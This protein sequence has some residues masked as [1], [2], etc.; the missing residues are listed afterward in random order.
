MIFRGTAAL[1]VSLILVGCAASEYEESYSR[2]ELPAAALVY[3]Q[4]GEQPLIRESD[5]L[6]GELLVLRK[7]GY[8]VLGV[9]EFTGPQE[10]DRGL[11]RQARRAGATL[12]LKSSE[13]VGS[14]TR[15]GKIY[16]PNSGTANTPGSITGTTRGGMYAGTSPTSAGVK[17]IPHSKTV[18][19]YKQTAVYLARRAD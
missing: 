3:L 4:E 1:L 6:A 2:R 10:G 13:F 15:E 5:Y 19:L 11:S 8:V 14:E 9:S 16:V 18:E 17:A 12:V 7:R